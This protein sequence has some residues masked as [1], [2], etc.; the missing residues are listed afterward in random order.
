MTKY[1]L[2]TLLAV[3]C[4]V[5]PLYFGL[6]FLF[7]PGVAPTGFGI[8]PWPTGNADGY[9]IV[10]GVRDLAVAAVTFLLLGLGQRRV[11]GWVVLINAF[12]PA[13]DALA[14]V[15]HG[16]SVATALIVHISAMTV[17]LATAALLLTER[18][19]TTESAATKQQAR[20]RA[21]ASRV[22]V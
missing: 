11:L 6:N 18:P 19:Q 21:T 3:L 1:R 15:T 20:P 17:V 5:A 8:E 10:K 4:A 16:G 14:V 7:A 9:F 13:G 2:T 12:I 22:G